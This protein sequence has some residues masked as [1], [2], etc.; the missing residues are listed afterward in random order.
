MPVKQEPVNVNWQ[1][2]YSLLPIV[3]IWAFYRI[4]KLRLALVILIPA[5]IGFSMLGGVLVGVVGASN[6]LGEGA[7]LLLML[8]P[9]SYLPQAILAIYLIRKWSKQWNEKFS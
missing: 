5:S 1:S 8:I 3:W 6:T 2:L 7:Y 9:I 4:E